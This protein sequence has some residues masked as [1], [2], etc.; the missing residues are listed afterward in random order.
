MKVQAYIHSL[1]DREHDRNVLGEA[2]ILE[3]IGDNLFLA[4][5]N[6]VRCTAIYNVFVG[7]YFVDDLYGRL[8]APAHAQAGGD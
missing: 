7:R 3:R 1:K 5:Y 2:E 6:G 4:E 8:D